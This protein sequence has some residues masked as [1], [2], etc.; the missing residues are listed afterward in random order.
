V[1]ERGGVLVTQALDAPV[2]LGLRQEGSARLP[3]L[4][5]EQ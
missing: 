3:Q 1:G 5:F 4:P 2:Q